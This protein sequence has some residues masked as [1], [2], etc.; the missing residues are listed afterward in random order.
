MEKEQ[1]SLQPELQHYELMTII[2]AQYTSEEVQSINEK[3]R[4]LLAEHKGSITKEDNLGK[5]KFAYQIEK[6]SHGT[7]LI[8]EFD[9]VP[10]ELN[11]LDR[12][13]RLTKEVL[14]FMIVKK[15]I[16]TAEEIQREEEIKKRIA[17]KQEEKEKSQE[18]PKKKKESKDKIKIEDLDKKLD[19]ILEGGDML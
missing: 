19:E 8:H 10:A 3:L 11:E 4:T 17:A 18:Q 5:L 2:P 9:M 7:Y 16:K 14:R 13:L 6:M 12:A 15:Q 1:E